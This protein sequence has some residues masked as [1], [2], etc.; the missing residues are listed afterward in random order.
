MSPS[1]GQDANERVA[2]YFERDAERFDAI[3]SGNSPSRIHKLVDRAFRTRLLRERYRAIEGFVDAG[4]RCL[5]IGSGSGRVAI[6]LALSKQ[7]RVLG[8]DI[9]PAMVAM[10]RERAREHG[11]EELCRFEQHDIMDFRSE[12]RFDCVL[13][14]GVLDYHPD[15]LPLLRAAARH[16]DGHLILT[17]PRMYYPLNVPRR[18]WLGMVKKCPL[19]FYTDGEVRELVE[20]LGGTL[21]CLKRDGL[22]GLIGNSVIKVRLPDRGSSALG[23]PELAPAVDPRRALT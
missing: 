13:A 6:S 1:E 23:G 8:V 19:R 14:S 2:S 5:E 22:P 11:V 10:A 21:V 12:G 3:Y 18:I 4:A 15:P 16:T 7:V 9:A 20:Q 17:Y